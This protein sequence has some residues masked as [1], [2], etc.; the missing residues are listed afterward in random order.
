MFGQQAAA[1]DLAH[2]VLQG[3]LAQ[4]GGGGGQGLG[5]TFVFVLIMLAIF[6]VLLWRPQQKQAKE[7]RAMI[8][9]LKKGDA[10][11]TNGG[12]IGKVHAV[13][14]KFIVLETGRDVKLR[15]LPGSIHSKAPEGLFDEPET[16]SD[17]D[18]EKDKK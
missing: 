14:E 15:V 9:S 18:K 16:R 10:V 13:A 7:H 8:A 2:D 11:I 6:Y 4:A 17:K 1:Q 3:L 5:Q 12:I